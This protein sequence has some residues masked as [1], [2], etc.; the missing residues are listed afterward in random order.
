[1]TTARKTIKKLISV[2]VISNFEGFSPFFRVLNANSIMQ[3][4]LT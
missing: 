1:M 2:T 3:Y 4:T